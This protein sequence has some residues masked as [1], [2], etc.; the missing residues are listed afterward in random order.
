[1]STLGLGEASSRLAQPGAGPWVGRRSTE[2]IVPARN[3]PLPLSLD[4][5]WGVPPAPSSQE[6]RWNPPCPHAPIG[7]RFTP[8]KE[9]GQFLRPCKGHPEKPTAQPHASELTGFPST[10]R[11]QSFLEQVHLAKTKKTKNQ[12]QHYAELGDGEWGALVGCG[13]LKGDGEWGAL[14]GCGDLKGDRV[15]ATG[16]KSNEPSHGA[17]LQGH[18][19]RNQHGLP[20]QCSPPH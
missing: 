14:A 18:R 15:Y 11:S 20:V 1:M 2:A 17:K 7:C 9:G 19:G 6:I 16:A 5:R 10:G 4:C 13:D 3:S 12:K 8:R